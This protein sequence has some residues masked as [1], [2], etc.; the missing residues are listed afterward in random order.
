MFAARPS[1]A[2]V[3]STPAGV[4][5]PA[6]A[7]AEGFLLC[8]PCPEEISYPGRALLHPLLHIIGHPGEPH[9]PRGPGLQAQESHP[10][11]NPG[12]HPLHLIRVL[13]EPQIYL[14]HPSSG[15]LTSPTTPSRGMFAAGGEI[16]MERFTTTS[17][18]I[19]QTQA[20]RLHAPCAA[21]PSWSRSWCRY[22]S[23]IL[24]SS[25]SSIIR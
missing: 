9:Q 3:L 13:P 2:A 21:I 18:H 1:G 16:S 12:R 5:S 17:Q 6:A 7:N 22:S 20:S 15:D 19:P 10:I 11:R 8:G 23:I 24:G 4:H 14:R 25:S